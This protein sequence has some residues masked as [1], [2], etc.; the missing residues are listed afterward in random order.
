MLHYDVQLIG[1]MVLHSGKIAEMAT[2]EGKTLVS[3][4]PAYL[5]ALAGEG[6]HIVT[7]NDYLAKRDSEWNGPIYEFLGL[8]VDCIDKHQPNSPERRKAYYADITYGTNNEFGFDYLRDN[9]VHNPDEMVQRK[10]HYAMVDEVDSVLI[11]DARTPLIISGPVPKGDEQQYHLM[12]PRVDKLVEAQKQVVNKNLIEARKKLAEGDDDPKSGGL[13]LIRAYRGLPK[14]SALIKFLS[15]PGIKVKLQKVENYYLADQQKE[16]PKVDEEL[17]FHIDEKNNQVDLT[18]RGLA[19]ITKS[20][21]DPDF[22]VLPDI[23]VSLAEI[24]K[25]ELSEEEKLHTKE[26]VLNDYSIKADRIH[27]VQQLLKAYTL[28]DKDVEYV[29]MEGAVKI[30]DEQTGRILDGRRYSDGLHQAIEAKENVK[31]EAATQTYATVT[32]QNFFRMYHKLCGMT[33]TAETEA[34]ELWGIYKL[35]VVT[36]PTNVQVIRKDEEDLVYKTKREKYKSV[37]D[38]IENL[39]NNG[40]PVLVGTTSVEVSELLSRMLQQ[41]K[42]PHNV[43]NAKQHAREAQVVAEAGLSGAITIATNMAGRGT[44]IKLGPGVK[45]AGG[46]AIIGTER[47]ESRRVDRQL[48]GRAGRQGDPGTTQFYVS[49]E[50]D[51]MRLFGSDRIAKLMDR[52]GYKEGEVIQHSMVTKSIERAQ[53]KVE[54]NNYGIRK[55][56][57]EYDDV[58]NKQRNVVYQKRN[59]ALFGERLALDLD[60]AFYTVAEGLISSFREQ[61][62]YEGFLLSTI[63]NFGLQSAISKEEFEKSDQNQLAERLY[64]EATSVYQ[65]KMEDLQKH[66]VPVFKNIRLTQGNH[67]ENVVV[68]FTDGRK[69][70]QVLANMQ[71]TLQT[72]GRELGNALERT[73]TLAIIDEAWKEHLRSMDDLKQS[74]QTAY[75]EQKDPLI[76][77]KMEAFEL[78]RRMDSEVN[79]DIVSFLCHSTIPVEQTNGQLREGREEK[80]DMSRMRA[81]KAE[82]AARGEDYAANE[83][84]YYDPT[85]VKQEPIKV[86]PKIGRNDPCPCGSGKK[87]KHCHG[88]EA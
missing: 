29:V 46:L 83:N 16:M 12:K 51:L 27:T 62:D 79:K 63:V 1:G 10:H 55:R 19:A 44:D 11:D 54:E 47:H 80:T 15:E 69:G 32:L 75:L 20:G 23:G 2:G 49:L 48:R 50:D 14:H 37:I 24:D 36:V 45:E 78:F 56:L 9:M 82:V 52:F 6:V 40:R 73:I 38:E 81:N 71:K 4:L 84:D 66:A 86:G 34:A 64:Q 13:A 22:F 17:Y 43:L 61:E 85:P 72:E 25:S 31:I 53:K 18:D 28:F 3:T 8:T 74:V 67:I 26:A 21:E 30:V 5:N 33:G 58:M 70:V 68:P 76:I 60:N 35:D 41:K 88:K 57:L 7:V 39:R 59:H 77:Y 65:R 87:Y 42:V